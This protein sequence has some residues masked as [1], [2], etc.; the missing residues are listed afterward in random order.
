MSTD[1]LIKVVKFDKGTGVCVLDRDE[2]IQKLNVIV[3]DTSKFELIPPST[4][5]NARHPLLRRQELVKDVINKHLA[6]YV[7]KELTNKLKPSGSNVGKLY[8]T[9][10]VH[11]KGF[12][13]RPIVSMINSPEY[14]LA[15]YLDSIIKP[16]IPATYCVRSN[17]EVIDYLSRFQFEKGDYCVSYDVVSLFTNI[18]LDETITLISNI[19]YSDASEKKPPMPK[20][21]F[22]ELLKTATG[23]LF[24]YQSTLYKQSDGVTMGNPLAPTLANF[25][26][27]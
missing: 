21:S 2:Y 22:I 15:K 9:C 26:L 8:G 4:R 10:K 13:M 23:G 6:K 16:G 14:N 17:T 19:L 12:P 1:T 25:L 20:C 5:K 11:K 24:S 18:P 27:N 3:N 7:P